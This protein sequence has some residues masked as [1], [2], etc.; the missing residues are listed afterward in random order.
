MKMWIL[1]FQD[2][3]IPC[4]TTFFPQDCRIPFNHTQS[5]LYELFDAFTD[6]GIGM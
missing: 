2:L 4:Q 3:A 6:N 1:F 5:A